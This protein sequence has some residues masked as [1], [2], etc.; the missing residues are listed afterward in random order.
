[1]QSAPLV[2]L[3][4]PL[5]PGP[6]MSSLETMQVHEAPLSFSGFAMDGRA[7]HARTPLRFSVSFNKVEGLSTAEGPFQIIAVGETRAALE[8]E[9][10]QALVFLWREYVAC[11][12]ID[13]SADA[14]ALREDLLSRFSGADHADG[15]AGGGSR[16]RA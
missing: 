13:F 10:N 3:S 15:E 2:H 11:P 16:P 9:V 12:P 4:Q 14:L 7:L 6:E 1:M 8:D 5:Q